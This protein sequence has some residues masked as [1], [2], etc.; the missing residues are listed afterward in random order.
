MNEMTGAELA[1]RVIALGLSLNDFQRLSGVA[2]FRT[3]SRQIGGTTAVSELSRATI[4]RLERDADADLERFNRATESGIPIE[5]PRLRD[6]RG[7]DKP[8]GYWHVIAARCI[9]VWGED[10]QIEYARA[11]ERDE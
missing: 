10:A 1:A 9:A 2:N 7:G 4:E 3:I 11:D 8:A 6:Q 5:I